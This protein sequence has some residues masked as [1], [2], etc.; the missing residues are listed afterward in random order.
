MKYCKINGQIC[1]LYNVKQLHSRLATLSK[2]PSA[3]LKGCLPNHE[4][5]NNHGSL[6]NHEGTNNHGTANVCGSLK[7]IKSNHGTDT[8]IP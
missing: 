5:T 3:E 7:S 8:N 4:G 6:P 2:Q 1:N